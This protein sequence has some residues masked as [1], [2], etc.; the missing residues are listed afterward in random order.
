MRAAGLTPCV[1][2]DISILEQVQQLL[3]RLL[4]G[5]DR[6]TAIFSLNHRTS[7]QV[8]QT[9]QNTRFSIPK[10]LALVG[11]DDV[12]LA[13]VLTPPLTT[14]SQSAADLGFRAATLLFER[15]ESQSGPIFD[16]AKIVLP[17][18]LIVRGSCGCGF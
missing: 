4:K 14:V 10:D 15:I 5:T 12:D 9:L 17:T 16:G 6:P 2:D 7:V 8:L 11:F 18:R 13:S 3:G 1:Y